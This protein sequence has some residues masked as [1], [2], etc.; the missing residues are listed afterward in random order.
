MAAQK[1]SGKRRPE[2]EEDPSAEVPEADAAE[3]SAV[4]V[5]EADDQWLDRPVGRTLDQ[6][7]E[8][9]VVEQLRELGADDEEEHR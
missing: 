6:A 1:R 8:A 2:I 9:D 7:S 3:Q 4:T 5:E